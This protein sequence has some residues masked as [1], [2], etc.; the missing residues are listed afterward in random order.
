MPDSNHDQNHWIEAAE[1]ARH[2]GTARAPAVLDV[3]RPAAIEASDRV[4]AGAR[5]RAHFAVQS[6]AAELDP[7]NE[8]IIYCVHG[9]NVSQSAA[10][11]LRS[12]G[13]RARALRDG[14]E[15]YVRAG[16]ITSAWQPK[17]HDSDLAAMEHGF[18]IY[19]AL[20]AWARD[21]AAAGRNCPQRSKFLET[22]TVE[23][24][25]DAI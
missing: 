3:R 13:F 22:K 17:L 24:T 16:G 7:E 25:R 18:A 5:W 1:L 2:I 9:H 11:L 15:G 21:G 8:V 20:Y 10:A 6:W 14:M 12:Y 4:I 19:D 23:H